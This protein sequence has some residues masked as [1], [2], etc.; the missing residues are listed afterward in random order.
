MVPT[1]V[2][3]S[4]SSVTASKRPYPLEDWPADRVAANPPI[5]A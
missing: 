5:V 2:V 1:G 3:S 4:I